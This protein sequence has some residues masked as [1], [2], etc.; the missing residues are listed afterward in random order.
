MK[1][2]IFLGAPGVGKGTMAE[3]LSK[4]YDYR[5]IS[6]GDILRR[7]TRNNTEL[8]QEAKQYVD[9]GQLVPDRVVAD[10]VSQELEN[11]DSSVPGIIFDGFP[12]TVE[13]ARHLDRVFSENQIQLT[14]AVLFEA[15]EEL[16]VKRLTARWLCRECGAIFNTLFNPPK[17]PAKCDSCGGELY[18]RSDDQEA[19]IRD[20]LQVYRKETAPLIDYYKQR[21]LLRRVFSGGQPQKNYRDLLEAL[22]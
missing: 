17:E 13:Q 3:K 15:D 12:R 2:Y 18:Q 4:D 9:S 22:K 14:A 19:T 5:H 10:M 20:R 21:G 1:T 8:G 7:E 11:L 16:I 6:T